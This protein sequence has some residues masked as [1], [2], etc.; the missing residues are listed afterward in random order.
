MNFTEDQL[1][2][3]RELQRCEWKYAA[4]DKDCVV[5]LYM[6]KPEKQSNRWSFDGEWETNAFS[7]LEKIVQWEDDKPFRFA[8]HAPLNRGY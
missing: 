5:I 3:M 1:A 6:Q 8:D 2:C 7:F 4:R